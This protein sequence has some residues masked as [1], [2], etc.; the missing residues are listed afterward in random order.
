MFFLSFFVFG[1]REEGLEMDHLMLQS[2]WIVTSMVMSSDGWCKSF[3]HGALQHQP[4]M[5]I[6]FALRRSILEAANK[7]QALIGKHVMQPKCFSSNQQ[8]F[9]LCFVEYFGTN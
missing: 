6:A 9:G 3:G 1:C 5:Q 7:H 4:A 2:A 8:V